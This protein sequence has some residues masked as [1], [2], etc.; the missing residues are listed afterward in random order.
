MG[1]DRE[2]D[3]LSLKSLAQTLTVFL[4]N[5][6]DLTCI[7]IQTKHSFVTNFLVADLD[8]KNGMISKDGSQLPKL[9]TFPYS[10]HSSYDELCHLVEAFKPNDIYPCT[11]DE[12]NWHNGMYLTI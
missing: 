2:E 11:V 5:K 4:G 3:E 12:L 9:I 10:R 8:C 6:G 7:Q 1:L